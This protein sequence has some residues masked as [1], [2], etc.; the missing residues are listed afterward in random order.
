MI[1]IHSL[2]GGGAERVARDLSAGWLEQGYS[3]SLVTQADRDV[4]AYVLAPGVQRYVLNTAGTSAHRTQALWKNWLR[5]RRLRALIKKHKPDILIGM[6]TTSSVL[7][8]NAARGLPCKVI[9]TEH[10]HPPSQSLSPFWLKARVQTY[11]QAAQVVA[12]TQGTADW[13]QAQIPSCKVSV[14]PNAVMWPMLSAEPVVPVPP[15]QGRQRLLAVG[16]LHPVKGF[17]VLLQAFASLTNYFPNWD[18]VILGEGALRPELEQAVEDLGL[19]DRVSLPGRV[20][21]VVDWYQDSDLYVLSSR[22]EGLSNTLLEAMATGLPAVAYDCD[23]GPREI[24]RP[25]ID[26]VL[27]RPVADVEALAAHLS[28]F[29]AHADKRHAYGQRAADVRDRF[30]SARIF[31]LWQQLLEQCLLRP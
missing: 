29:M 15:R 11:P 25:G 31:A 16:R 1:V 17:D 28:D 7:C 3:V 24:I 13:L 22:M 8:I 30:S 19:Q 26:G 9:A 2:A 12:L 10:T 27:V 23:T 18:L 21:N 4:D 14:I 5:L 6:M 20:G